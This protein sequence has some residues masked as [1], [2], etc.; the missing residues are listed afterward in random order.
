[1]TDTSKIREF[2]GWSPTVAL[3][4][5]LQDVVDYYRRGGGS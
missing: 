2:V 3:P 4:Q 1:M 5:I